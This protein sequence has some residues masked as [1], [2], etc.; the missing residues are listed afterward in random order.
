[1]F[2]SAVSSFIFVFCPH[3]FV[4]YLL[5]AGFHLSA[6]CCTVLWLSLLLFLLA[7]FH[8][9]LC[10]YSLFFVCLYECMWVVFPRENHPHTHISPPISH[11]L[12]RLVC[13]FCENISII[14]QI[15][16]MRNSAYNLQLFGWA[17]WTRKTTIV[18]GLRCCQQF[19]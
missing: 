9:Y 7:S 11:T 2:C 17:D 5:F 13:A 16:T 12:C 15:D 6:R 10:R 4:C 18:V 1:L 19:G 8:S 14:C 3:F